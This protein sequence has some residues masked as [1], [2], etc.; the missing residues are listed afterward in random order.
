MEFGHTINKVPEACDL[1][2]CQAVTLAAIK[3]GEEGMDIRLQIL[4]TQ[5]IVGGKFIRVR[6]IHTSQSYSARH[7]VGNYGT[8]GGREYRGRGLVGWD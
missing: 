4:K 1:L 7:H 5:R 3:E 8:G 2:P 6:N